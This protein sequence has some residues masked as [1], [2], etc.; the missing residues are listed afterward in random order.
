MEVIQA[1]AQHLAELAV[2]GMVLFLLYCCAIVA[3]GEL[4][5]LKRYIHSRKDGKSY[6]QAYK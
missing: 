6:G 2:A 1:I 3:Y 5:K 4:M